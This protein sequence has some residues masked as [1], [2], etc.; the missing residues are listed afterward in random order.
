MQL[1]VQDKLALEDLYVGQRFTS[2]TITID[3]VSMRRFATQFDP[4]PFHLSDQGARGSLFGSIAASGWHTAALTNRLCIES[5]PISTGVIGGGAQLEW[6]LP[7]R[8]G[9]S[10]QLFSEVV[11]I[12]PSKSRPDRATVSIRGETRKANGEVLQVL[13][14]DLL[15]FRRKQ[16]D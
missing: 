11:K 15:V 8:P 10:L 14:A 13:T 2:R 4:Q 1:A 7:T 5:I 12:V 16:A 6:R 3:E 9:D